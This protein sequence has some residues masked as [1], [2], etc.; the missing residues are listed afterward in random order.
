MH[1]PENLRGIIA[2]LIAVALFSVMDAQL[3]L[4]AAHYGPMQVSFLRGATSLPFVLLPILTLP[5]TTKPLRT[6]RGFVEPRE[7]NPVLKGTARLSLAFSLLFALGLALSGFAPGDVS[8]SG[9]SVLG[10]LPSE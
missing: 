1:P 7:L 2:M 4:L 3:K 9:P 8:P 5:M 6:V 10:Q